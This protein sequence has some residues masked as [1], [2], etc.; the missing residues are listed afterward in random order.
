MRKEHAIRVAISHTLVSTREAQ[1]M[2]LLLN[3]RAIKRAMQ[4][5]LMMIQRGG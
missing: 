4:V 2:Y 1:K 3:P 5:K